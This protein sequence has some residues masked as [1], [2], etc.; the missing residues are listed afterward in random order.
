[1]ASIISAT[2]AA[3][4]AKPSPMTN[5]RSAWPSRMIA[6]A[7]VSCSPQYVAMIAST[8]APATRILM[9]APEFMRHHCTA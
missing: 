1:M 4:P 5:W 3:G 7:P 8:S 6:M 2:M 9:R